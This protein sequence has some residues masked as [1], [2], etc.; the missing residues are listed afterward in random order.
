MPKMMSD[1]MGARK[2]KRKRSLGVYNPPEQFTDIKEGISYSMDTL[3][4]ALDSTK[5][6]K[7]R[8]MN[9]QMFSSTY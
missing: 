5:K 8:E 6:R 3:S 1:M 2:P 4:P 7:R 9:N